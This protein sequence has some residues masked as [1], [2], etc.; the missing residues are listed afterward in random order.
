ML[1]PALPIATPRLLLRPLGHH[2]LDAVYAIYSRPDVHRYLYW[3]PRTRSDVAEWLAQRTNRTA[4]EAEGDVLSLGMVL[5]ESGTFVGNVVLKWRSAE[6]QQGE[7]GF[8]LHPDHH[9]RGL[10]GEAAR[11]MLEL[12]FEGLR[13][14]RIV[15]RCDARNKA[16]A[17]VMEK[18]GMR[19]EAHLQENEFIHGEWTDEYVYAML[20]SE[21]AE[22]APARHGR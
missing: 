20:G 5:P 8:V 6:H 22:L 16:S 19:R 9:G 7:V 4:L 12:G 2:D 21:W 11:V 10:A 17:R 1:R 13:L 18:L 14:H 15:G 3:Q